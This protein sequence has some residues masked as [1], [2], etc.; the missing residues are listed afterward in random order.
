[1]S[2]FSIPRRIDWAED[3]VFS[4]GVC[5]W[6]R[7]PRNAPDAILFTSLCDPARNVPL[8]SALATLQFEE[9][10]EGWR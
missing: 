6:Q 4:I 1:M 9:M 8:D 10:P 5:M 7:R 3:Q 2:G